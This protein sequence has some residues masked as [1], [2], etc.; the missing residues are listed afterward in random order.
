VHKGWGI[1]KQRCSW[2]TDVIFS[3]RRIKDEDIL[4][5]VPGKSIRLNYHLL[6]EFDLNAFTVKRCCWCWAFSWSAKASPSDIV[7]PPLTAVLNNAMDLAI[8]HRRITAPE[9]NNFCRG[10]RK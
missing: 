7:Y 4:F 1:Y 2:H 8:I 6:I 9:E 10:H 5:G 3:F